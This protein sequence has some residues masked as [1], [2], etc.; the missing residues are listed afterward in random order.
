MEALY[1]A[2][3]RGYRTLRR[4][5]PRI[6]A[7]IQK[8]LGPARSVLNVGA[9]AGSYEPNDRRVVAV[10]ISSTMIDQRPP[11]SAPVIQGSGET[12]PFPDDSFDAC[13]AVLTLH[14][15]TDQVAGLREMRRVSRGTHVILTWDP[16]TPSFWLTD[17]FPEILEIDR[18][19]FPRTESYRLVFDS[20]SIHTVEIPHDCTDGF[21]GAYW[22][23]PAAY[24]EDHVRSAISTF[25][26]IE[27]VRD[28]LETLRIELENGVWKKRYGDLLDLPTLDLG[29]RLV[30]ARNEGH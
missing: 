10:E 30:V 21:L 22:R 15:W 6:E 29:Y 13:L 25:S 4:P 5:D 2:I 17:Y 11:G 23:R 18:K 12:L 7:N 8:A 3:G 28:G 27:G 26:K 24:L 16:Q 20:V 9:G 1:D 19:I 14:H